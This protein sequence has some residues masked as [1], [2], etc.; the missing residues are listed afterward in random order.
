[1]NTLK[2][3]MISSAICFTKKR[4]INLKSNF[5]IFAL[6]YTFAQEF[7]SRKLSKLYANQKQRENFVNFSNQVKTFWPPLYMQ[8]D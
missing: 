2:I 8:C 6:D 7:Q 3:R 1:M 4:K 5:H